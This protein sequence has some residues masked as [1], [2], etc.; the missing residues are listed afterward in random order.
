MP[1]QSPLHPGDPRRIGRYRVGG[2][3]TGV[4]SDDPIF[5]GLAPDGS[6]VAISLIR[7]E[8]AHDGAARDR[9]AAEAAVAKRVPP[10]CAAR[11]LDAGLDNTGA[12]LVS[13]YVPGLSL[14]ELVVADGVRLGHELEAIAIGMATGLASVHQA[15][16]VHGNF[17]PE[18]VIT[19]ETGPPRVIEFGI[20][21]PYGTATP[22]ADMLAWGETVIFA[23][24]GRP[25]ASLDDVDLL[26]E[27]LREP[28]ELCLGSAPSERP[29]ARAV[30][31]L[32]LGD[33]EPA[34]GLLAEGSRRAARPHAGYGSVATRPRPHGSPP[35][36]RYPADRHGTTHLAS[37]RRPERPVGARLAVAG[38]HSSRA[39]HGPDDRRGR[40]AGPR[41]SPAGVSARTLQREP[42]WDERAPPGRP[43]RRSRAVWLT[44]GV[45]VVIAVLGVVIMHLVQ[46]SGSRAAAGASQDGT[47]GPSNSTSG[48]PS[49][50]PVIPTAFAGSW[51]GHVQQAQTTEAVSITLR[52]GGTSGTIS[53]SGPLLTCTGELTTAAATATQLTLSQGIVQGQNKCANGRVTLA[54]T[55][56]GRLRF[57][58]QGNGPATSGTLRQG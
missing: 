48:S 5:I 14:L 26:P 23:A 17:G 32:L 43:G 49:Q 28:V 33:G 7:G 19:T 2:R 47:N 18:Y 3:I 25:P 27:D 54:T 56:P 50:A 6:E 12:F 16:L 41:H 53:Y 52:A 1:Q 40:P 11:V 24:T 58:F 35:G 29:A 51:S 39:D 46:N 55:S 4:P 8:W 30:I 31:Q 45:V 36:Q 44:A 38:Q 15:G 37:S 42:G 34:A 10:F 22:S 20:T 21:P 57:T 9:F 13:E